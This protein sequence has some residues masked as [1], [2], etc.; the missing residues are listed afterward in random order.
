MGS[1]ETVM[2][3]S[4]AVEDLHGLRLMALLHEL[5]REK[6]QRG[7][8]RALGV[9]R[10]TVAAC[11]ESGE[12]SWR[13]REA[14]ERGLQSEA[15]SAGA[16]QRER[17]EALEQRMEALEEELRGR[18]EGMRLALESGVKAMRGEQAETVRGLERR[19]AK[20]EA[21]QGGQGDA[22]PAEAAGAVGR[23][24]ARTASRR[25]YPDLVTVG[26]EPGEEDVYGGAMPLIVEWRK[27]RDEFAAARERL[28]RVVA[29]ERMRE[30][31]IEMIEKR[32][33][34][35]PP[36]T[37][38]W[39]ES[40]RRDEVRLREQTLARVRVERARAQVRRWLRR[41]LTLGLWWE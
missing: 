21:R 9:N 37:W 23:P 33:L 3:Q 40:R 4:K 26:P 1:G 19:L 35:L 17:V 24:A 20:V 34:T 5:A 16:R 36:S 13:M 6:G 41:V 18:L 38:L 29:E 12:M 11:M 31:E 14:L 32:R 25:E 2:E 7:T 8:A 15:G 39:D 10:R 30:L 28:A 22:G 27:V